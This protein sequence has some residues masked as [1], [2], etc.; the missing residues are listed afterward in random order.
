MEN[1][2]YKKLFEVKKAGIKLQRDTKAFNYKYAQLSQIQTKLWDVLQEQW[3]LIVH[4]IEDNKVKTGIFDIDTKEFITSSIAL[5]EWLKAQDKWSEITYY[6]RYNL[7]SLLDLETKDDDGKKAQESKPKYEENNLEWIWKEN[8]DTL[9][10]I[11]KSW[12]VMTLRQVREK[13]KVSKSNAEI[14]KNLWIV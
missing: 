11:V 13:Y 5:T 7:L 1:N 12:N 10:K 4:T 8:I 9:E 14:L 2:I 6:R 3:L